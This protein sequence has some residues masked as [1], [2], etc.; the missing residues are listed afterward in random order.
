MYGD[1][2]NRIGFEIS[3][4]NRNYNLHNIRSEL[5]KASKRVSQNFMQCLRISRKLYIH[6]SLYISASEFHATVHRTRTNLGG[7]M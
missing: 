4:C 6:G 2:R 5:A 7:Y 3:F 1:P